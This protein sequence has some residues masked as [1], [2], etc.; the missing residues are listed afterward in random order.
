[1]Y[2]ERVLRSL[3]VFFFLTPCLSAQ[4][5]ADDIEAAMG[6][7][8]ALERNQTFIAT[9]M[10]ERNGESLAF[11]LTASDDLTRFEFGDRT[12]VR[13]GILNQWWDPGQKRSD[14]KKGLDGLREICDKTILQPRDESPGTGPFHHSRRKRPCRAPPL[15]R[16]CGG[17]GTDGSEKSHPPTWRCPP[18]GIQHLVDHVQPRTSG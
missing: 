13:N 7:R 1:M 6:G 8:D 15:R 14:L 4:S 5:V 18:L 3:L 17:G 12:I 16:L 2:P 10:L 9:G 11:T